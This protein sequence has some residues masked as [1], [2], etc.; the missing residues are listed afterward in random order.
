MPNEGYPVALAEGIEKASYHSDSQVDSAN[1]ERNFCM[2]SKA[3]QVGTIL[4][5]SLAVAAWA[6]RSAQ[7]GADLSRF[8]ALIELGPVYKHAD[9][10]L[11]DVLMSIAVLASA[12]YATDEQEIAS[13]PQVQRLGV[14]P[15][16]L[17]SYLV[18]SKDTSEQTELYYGSNTNGPVKVR[19]TRPDGRTVSVVFERHTDPDISELHQGTVTY[20]GGEEHLQIEFESSQPRLAVPARGTEGSTGVVGDILAW[21]EAGTLVAKYHVRAKSEYLVALRDMVSSLTPEQLDS[22]KISLTERVLASHAYQ[23]ADVVTKRD[24]QGVA[25]MAERYLPIS[26]DRMREVLGQNIEVE[27]I[28]GG[29]SATY[30]IQEGIRPKVTIEFA[31]ESER[32]QRVRSEDGTILIFGFDSQP[33]LVAAYSRAETPEE[34]GWTIGFYE[35]HGIP[36]LAFNRAGNEKNGNHRIEIWDSKG[37]SVLSMAFESAVPLRSA[38]IEVDTK[39]SESKKSLVGWRGSSQELA[40]LLG[41]K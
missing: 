31:P 19:Q 23:N 22:L 16:K 33:R 14:E 38:I 30:V 17:R 32:L 28:T 6:E 18:P 4:A 36:R 5:C 1:A 35:S 29:P 12:H 11:K 39:L 15:E 9:E 2:K 3:I 7:L 34:T 26:E 8:V 25:S 27:K 20:G 13:L 21:D 37:E 10:N 24:L 40:Y 41:T